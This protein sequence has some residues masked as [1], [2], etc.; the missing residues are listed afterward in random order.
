MASHEEQAVA[1][2]EVAAMPRSAEN[3]RQDLPEQI[4]QGAAGEGVVEAPEVTDESGELVQQRFLQFL[5]TLY[6]SKDSMD[7]FFI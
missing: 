7:C 6:V 2:A 5:G 1:M 3:D 4:Q